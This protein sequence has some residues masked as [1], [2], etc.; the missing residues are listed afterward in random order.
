MIIPLRFR[1]LI[2]LALG[3]MKKKVGWIFLIFHGE[4]WFWKLLNFDI[5]ALIFNGESLLLFAWGILENIDFKN[6]NPRNLNVKIICSWKFSYSPKTYPIWC[7]YTK[8]EVLTSKSA[9]VRMIFQF[10][11]L[12]TSLFISFSM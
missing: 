11:V 4:N 6:Q 9:K 8:Y 5:F 12:L 7:N 2:V 3:K 1:I 10:L